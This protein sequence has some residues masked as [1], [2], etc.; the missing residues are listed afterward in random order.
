MNAAPAWS[1]HLPDVDRL[2][3]ALAVR[4]EGGVTRAADRLRLTQ[5]AVSRLVAALEAD[6]GFALF[7]RERRRLVL[8]EQGQSY[9]AEAEASVGALLR[10]SALG[11]E[12]RLGGRGLI[13]IAAVSVLAH[14]VLPHALEALRRNLPEVAIEINEVERD[15]QVQGLLAGRFDLGLLALPVG[16]PGLRVEVLADTEAVCLLPTG[17]KLAS[18]P[19]LHAADLVGERFIAHREGKLMRQRVD[20]A[21]GHVDAVRKVAVTTDST[22]LAASLVAAGLGL[23]IVHPLPRWALPPGIVSRPFRP[24]LGFGYAAITRPAE[25]GEELTGTL[26]GHVR[27]LLAAEGLRSLVD[28]G[29]SVARRGGSRRGRHG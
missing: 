23:A 12:L 2:R 24:R 4:D 1:A 20:D 19:V 6:L 5:P 8:T 15:Q 27:R 16:A 7:A 10:L 14:G 21:F 3:A 17:H 13:R 9:L 25:R 29:T 18:R 22:P 28:P 11:R 26:L